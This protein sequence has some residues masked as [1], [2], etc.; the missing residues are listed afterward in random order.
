MENFIEIVLNSIKWE[1]TKQERLLF[2]LN[3]FKVEELQELAL[4]MFQNKEQ[5]HYHDIR[6]YLATA[7]GLEENNIDDIHD[8]LCIRKI[9]TVSNQGWGNYI[10]PN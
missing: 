7:E 10:I 2:G 5:L 8:I 3:H 9:I 1:Y 6:N 4:Q